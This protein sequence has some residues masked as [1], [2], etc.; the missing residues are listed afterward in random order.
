MR[1]PSTGELTMKGLQS[2]TF[3]WTFFLL[4]VFTSVFALLSLR[5]GQ[6]QL[7]S[8]IGSIA[9]AFATILL[10]S[11]TA[12]YAS[13]TQQ[14]VD[15]NEKMRIQTQNQRREEQRRKVDAL[16]RALHEE[17]GKVSRIREW[18]ENNSDQ[19][20]DSTPF[21]TDIYKHNTDKIGLLTPEEV[22]HI[23][24]YYTFIDHIEYITETKEYSASN[25][26]SGVLGKLGKGN[27]G[28]EDAFIELLT[29]RIDDLADAQEK[30]L[31]SI[32]DQ[33]EE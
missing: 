33:L 24:A 29:D 11:L 31:E 25:G 19:R 15:E 12:Q 1:I 8:Q 9:S 16:R 20:L 28:N 22:D 13:Q 2:N 21:P 3:R 5:N 32:E 18:A 30:A 4:T 6:F 27:G 23:V 26:D 17:I 14:L 7:G 10:V